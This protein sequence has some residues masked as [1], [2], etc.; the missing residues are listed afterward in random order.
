MCDY[1]GR[2]VAE[3]CIFGFA[4][5]INWRKFKK[6]TYSNVKLE[7]WDYSLFIKYCGIIII[8]IVSSI[9]FFLKALFEY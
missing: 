4:D 9:I 2:F 8:L 1:R 3:N 7:S 6:K 5:Y